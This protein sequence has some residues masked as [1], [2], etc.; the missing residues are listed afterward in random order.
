M[1]SMSADTV[2]SNSRGSGRRVAMRLVRAKAP[3][4]DEAQLAHAGAVPEPT[5]RQRW[6]R[7]ESDKS[8]LNTDNEVVRITTLDIRA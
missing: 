1:A 8:G 7:G 5:K 3:D 2:R 6:T 4:A